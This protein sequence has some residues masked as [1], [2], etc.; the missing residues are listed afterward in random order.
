MKHVVLIKKTELAIAGMLT[1]ASIVLLFSA[2][3][4]AGAPRVEAATVVQKAQA[5]ASSSCLKT[6]PALGAKPSTKGSSIEVSEP[7]ARDLASML[8]R[9]SLIL[10]S[11]PGYKAEEL[12]AGDGCLPERGLYLKLTS[13]V[14]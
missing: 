8:E 13:Q 10:Q 5:E 4:I 14:G 2:G 9:A 11:C 1:V 7:G 3:R 6:L 12:C